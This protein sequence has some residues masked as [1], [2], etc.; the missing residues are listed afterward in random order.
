MKFTEQYKEI[1]EGKDLVEIIRKAFGD[2]P[3]YMNVVTAKDEKEQKEAVDTLIK[4]RGANAY[5]KFQTFIA[6]IK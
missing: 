3:L 1:I 4:I 6:Q 5:K 2:D